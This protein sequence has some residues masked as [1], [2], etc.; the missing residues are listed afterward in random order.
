[1]AFHENIHSVRPLLGCTCAVHGIDTVRTLIAWL[2][3]VGVLPAGR[4]QQPGG[5]AC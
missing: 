4:L 2:V 1:M 5:R 3:Q